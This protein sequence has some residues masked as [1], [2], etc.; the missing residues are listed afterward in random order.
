MRSIS[1]SQKDLI[2]LD[3]SLV[4]VGLRHGLF[5]SVTERA[6]EPSGW[7]AVSSVGARR[8]PIGRKL[9]PRSRALALW[10]FPALVLSHVD[11]LRPRF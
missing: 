3:F 10:R 6:L 5:D 4:R 7:A 11:L 9:S 1:C 8:L 2:L